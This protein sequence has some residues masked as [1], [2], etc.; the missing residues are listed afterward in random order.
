MHALK[1]L[2]QREE[3]RLQFA[4]NIFKNE[5]VRERTEIS[6][7]YSSHDK[8]DSYQNSFHRTFGT[9]KTSQVSSC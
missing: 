6:L 8:S 7:L 3:E 1:R 4:K 2:E 5:N 9:R